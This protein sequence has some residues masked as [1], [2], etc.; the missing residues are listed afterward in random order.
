[1]T[2]KKLNLLIHTLIYP[3]C[4]FEFCMRFT[5]K[6]GHLF[7]NDY[8]NTNSC[9]K[10]VLEEDFS[11][12]AKPYDFISTTLCALSARRFFRKCF[13]RTTTITIM[14]ISAQAEPM[15][16]ARKWISEKRTVRRKDQVGILKRRT[17]MKSKDIV[18]VCFHP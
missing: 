18:G 15:A 5:Q 3:S 1:M 13:K 17:V 4:E 16:R 14:T 7:K 11:R 2:Q 10:T 12:T 8:K 9:H 6:K